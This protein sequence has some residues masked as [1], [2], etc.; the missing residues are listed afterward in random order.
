MHIEWRVIQCEYWRRGSGELFD[1]YGY[2][3]DQNE[4]GAGGALEMQNSQDEAYLF[5]QVSTNTF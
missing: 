5:K 3:R 4:S 2:V 1:I